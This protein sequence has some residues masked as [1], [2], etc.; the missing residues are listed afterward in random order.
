MF[1]Q[2]YY[3]GLICGGGLSAGEAYTRCKKSFSE[4]MIQSSQFASLKSESNIIF[5]NNLTNN[6]LWSVHHYLHYFTLI[7]TA[8]NLKVQVKHWI[9]LYL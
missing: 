5:D 7:A 9:A 6:Y 3:G 8:F 2:G 1:L 4:K